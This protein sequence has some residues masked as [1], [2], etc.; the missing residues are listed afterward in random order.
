MAQ[1]FDIEPTWKEIY[2]EVYPERKRDK[3]F[4]SRDL[5]RFFQHNLDEYEQEH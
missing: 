2:Y 4:S 5:I 1:L 3:T